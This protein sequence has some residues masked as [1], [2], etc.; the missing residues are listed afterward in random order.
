MALYWPEQK[1]ALE[2]VDDPLARPFDYQNLRGWRVLQV[3]MAQVDDLEESRK[4]GDALAFMLGE[5]PVE[6][7]PEW[8]EANERLHRELTAWSSQFYS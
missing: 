1:V 8:L 5:P 6:K 3:T 7:T 4:I 2:I